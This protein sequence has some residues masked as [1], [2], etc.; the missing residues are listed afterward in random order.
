M[1][2]VIH[3]LVRF[4]EP[5]YA[6]RAVILRHYIG[7][8]YARLGTYLQSRSFNPS[9]YSTWHGEDVTAIEA[10][11]VVM[12]MRDAIEPEGIVPA[13]IQGIEVAKIEAVDLI[14]TGDFKLGG[15]YS[16]QVLGY[17]PW[18]IC[19]SAGAQVAQQLPAGHPNFEVPRYTND[20]P[21]AADCR[22]WGG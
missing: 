1:D 17:T 12:G 4:Q 16:P 5:G 19:R 3:P 8:L 22:N 13:T 20:T 21:A 11:D 15:I 14:M 9:Q 7:G 18:E 10:W 2:S 6:L